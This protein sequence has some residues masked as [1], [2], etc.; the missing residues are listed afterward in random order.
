MNTF[1]VS[2][3]RQMMLLLAP[4]PAD[5]IFYVEQINCFGW[6]LQSYGGILFPL[7]CKP[8]RIGNGKNVTS[9]TLV[10]P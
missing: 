6:F 5:G 9:H 10:K 1:D 7:S 2:L 3:S 4:A 8:K